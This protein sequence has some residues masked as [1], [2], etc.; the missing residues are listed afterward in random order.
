MCPDGVLLDDTPFCPAAVPLL[1]AT[2]ASDDARNAGALTREPQSL[3]TPPA[4]RRCPGR[5]SSRLGG[6]GGQLTTVICSLPH[7]ECAFLDNALGLFV[8]VGS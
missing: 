6:L 3:F 1:L 8:I 4:S 7:P 2:S 5:H